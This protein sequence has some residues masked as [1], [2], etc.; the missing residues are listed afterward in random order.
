M[1][2]K[3][4]RFDPWLFNNLQIFIHQYCSAERQ[5]PGTSVYSFAQGLFMPTVL[6][7]LLFPSPLPKERIVEISKSCFRVKIPIWALHILVHE[8]K[9]IKRSLW[10]YSFNHFKQECSGGGCFRSETD[11]IRKVCTSPFHQ[12]GDMRLKTHLASH[13]NTE[14]GEKFFFF[15]QNHTDV[16]AVQNFNHIQ[17]STEI[18]D[19]VHA[20]R[21]SKARTS[22]ALSA[23]TGTGLPNIS[24]HKSKTSYLLGAGTVSHLVQRV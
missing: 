20:L 5:T 8:L 16:L 18:K 24:P 1:A 17:A 3:R 19:H 9:R 14:Q 23:G 22:A 6:I 21:M 15:F 2:C 7:F 13:S 10:Y 12:K 11:I 4:D